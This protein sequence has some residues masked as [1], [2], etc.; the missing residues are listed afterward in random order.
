MARDLSV[1]VVVITGAS[2]GIGLAAAEAF[3]REGSTLVLAARAREPL[4]H[5][6]RACERLGATALVVSTDVRDERQVE[7]L[8]SQAVERFGRLDV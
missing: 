8:A 6:A 1:C 7:L 2:S 5:A 3:A 4:E